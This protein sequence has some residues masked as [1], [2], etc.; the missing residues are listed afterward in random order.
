[1][2]GALAALESALVG[3]FSSPAAAPQMES[4]FATF[5]LAVAGGMA[6][7]FV[8]TPPSKPVGFADSFLL[9]NPAT[10]EEGAA[11]LR[12]IIDTWMRLGTA[13]PSSGGLTI[14]WS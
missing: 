12:Q 14:F 13:T 8:A 3:A 2:A 7:A 5:G 9:D 10:H 1:M 4:A 11:R 6:P